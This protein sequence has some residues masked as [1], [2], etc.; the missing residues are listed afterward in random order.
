MSQYDD[1]GRLEERYR[2]VHYLRN[3][4]LQEGGVARAVL[5]T[6]SLLA[7]RGHDVTLLTVDARDVPSA[8]RTSEKKLP[9]AVAI[10]APRFGAPMT[11]E[12]ESAI[13]SAHVLHLHTPWELSNLS[14]AR[15][16][17]RLHVPYIVSVHGMLDRWSLRQKWLKKRLFLAWVGRRFLT[18]AARVHCTAVAELEQAARLLRPDSGVVIPCPIDLSAFVELPGPKRALSDYPEL[19]GVVPSLLFLSRLHPK[20]RPDLLIEAAAI[21]ARAGQHC[22]VIL[23]GPGDAGYVAW[24]RQRALQ[25][26]LE[27]RVLFTGMVDGLTKISLFQA[28][29]VFVLPTSQENFGIVLVEAMAAGTPVVTTRGVDIWQELQGAG[30]VIVDQ[31]PDQI[32]TAIGSLVTDLPKA[33]ER[34]REGRAW[35]FRELDADRVIGAYERMYRDVTDIAA[36]TS[37]PAR[38]A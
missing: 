1:G 5:D 31:D 15:C 19:T 9:R 3:I 20:K 34:G 30:A 37:S 10:P 27:R 36:P 16:A 21:M 33:K 25:S 13:R 32:A 7:K 6:C 17:K 29:D 28:A 11:M 18:G 26:G 35:A 24:L 14:L 38:P 4:R 8:W 22:Q 2:C 23:A 12:A